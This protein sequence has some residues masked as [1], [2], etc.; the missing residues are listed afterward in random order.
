MDSTDWKM[1]LVIVDETADAEALSLAV[2]LFRPKKED[3]PIVASGDVIILHSI[4][5]CL[6]HRPPPHRIDQ[7]WLTAVA[8]SNVQP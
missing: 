4:K 1:T 2:N 7:L 5:A 8:V 3:L 6:D